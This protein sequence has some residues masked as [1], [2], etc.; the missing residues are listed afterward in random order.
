MFY[1][2]NRSHLL[3]W[4]KPAPPAFSARV[5][6]QCLASSRSP[7]AVRS[8]SAIDTPP[9]HTP[10]RICGLGVWHPVW[11]MAPSVR[12]HVVGLRVCMALPLLLLSFLSATGRWIC[13]C[14][15]SVSAI[16]FWLGNDK[17]VRLYA[18]RL[19]HLLCLSNGPTR[20]IFSRT[21]LY[22]HTWH[23]FYILTLDSN[24]FPKSLVP[25]RSSGAPYMA[26][27][28]PVNPHWFFFRR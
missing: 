18:L 20:L 6:R 24:S 10:G 15:F 19:A 16:P 21:F 4:P 23:T 17:A 26:P 25:G 8:W 1:K 9:I 2:L 22:H 3:I 11:L 28:A 7:V 14:G 13:Y 27:G 5:R 12:I